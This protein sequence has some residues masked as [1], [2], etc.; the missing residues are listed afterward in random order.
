MIV[1]LDCSYKP[2]D[3][4]SGYFLG[5]LEKNLNQDTLQDVRT[6]SIKDV[7]MGMHMGDFVNCLREAEALVFG[8]P[9]YVDGLPAQVVKLFEILLEQYQGTLYDLG[10]YVVSN[11]GFYESK[12]LRHMLDMVRNWCMRMGCRYGG[13]LAIGAGPLVRSVGPHKKLKE[14][15]SKMANAIIQKESIGNVYCDPSIPRT[16]YIKAAHASFRKTAKKNNL[17]PDE[18]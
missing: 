4:N 7:L 8:V 3:S 2:Q 17:N 15:F 5:V 13:G 10:I 12:Q 6:W 1:L 14:A 9:L 16:V 11:L 18:I